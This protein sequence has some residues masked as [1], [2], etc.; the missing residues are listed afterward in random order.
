MWKR[1]LVASKWRRSNPQKIPAIR[2]H[3]Y[4]RHVK[5]AFQHTEWRLPLHQAILIL[6]QSLAQSVTSQ[7]HVSEN[8]RRLHVAMS[9][10]KN[11]ATCQGWGMLKTF[12]WD[13]KGYNHRQEYGSFVRRESWATFGWYLHRSYPAPKWFFCAILFSICAPLPSLSVVTWQSFY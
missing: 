10:E 4:L 8:F 12:P 9:I 6:Q 1:L 11:I 2:N 5:N 13:A 3:F 7:T